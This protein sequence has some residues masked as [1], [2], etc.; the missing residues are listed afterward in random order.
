VHEAPGTDTADY[1]ERLRRI[2]GARWKRVL[3]TQ[4]PYRWHIRRLNLGHTLD[5]G[6]GIG[7][8]LGHLRGNGVGVDHNLTSVRFC[9]SQGLAAY[10]ID[11]FFASEHAKPETFDALLAAHLLEH[12]PADAAQ[13]IVESYLPFVRPGGRIVFITPQERGYASDAT[14]VRFVGFTEAAAVASALDLTVHRQYSFP[15]PRTAG[16]IFTYNE[17]VTVASKP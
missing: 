17:F 14:H 9:R 11:E 4:A 7:R 16:R 5:V 2:G 12:V 10:T 3:D 15:L 1:T 8:N 13:Q 6:C